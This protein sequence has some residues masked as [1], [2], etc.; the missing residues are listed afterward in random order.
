MYKTPPRND[1]FCALHSA[2]SFAFYVVVLAVTMLVLHPAYL[3]IS[4]CSAAAYLA[5]LDTPRGL[6]RRLRWVLPFMVITVIF[7]AMFSHRGM[8]VLFYLRNGN[9]VTLESI[10]FGLLASVMLA[11][12]VLWFA[13]LHI[14]LT[15]EKLM[16]VTGRLAPALSLLLSMAL[17][18]VPRISRQIKRTAQAQRAL[19]PPAGLSDRLR[20]GVRVLSV[21]VSVALENAVVTAD[22]MRSRGYGLPGRTAFRRERWGARERG[23]AALFVPLA[24]VVLAGLLA[25][26][27]AANF[28]PSL[29]FAAPDAL[30]A[31][32]R[33]AFTLLC[34]LP[35]LLNRKEALT[36]RR[37]RSNI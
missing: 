4:L 37:L 22:S 24:A 14:V 10:V 34:N 5:A 17:R 27:A 28:Y 11:A 36:W 18:F 15:S 30:G 1:A 29:D 3:A 12:T 33:A 21:T 32:S 26:R 31:A 35:L 19:Y 8:T 16:A 7:N 23:F 25:G 20:F 6:L 13:S 2:L 9:A